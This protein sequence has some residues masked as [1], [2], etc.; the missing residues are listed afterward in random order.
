MNVNSSKKRAAIGGNWLVGVLGLEVANIRRGIGRLFA[1]SIG[2]N[3]GY[4]Q[5][6]V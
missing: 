5:D 4:G 1:M 2:K 3:Q 6:F